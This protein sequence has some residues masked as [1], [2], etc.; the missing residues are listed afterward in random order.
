MDDWSDSSVAGQV[1]ARTLNAI[2][3]APKALV[4]ETLL[5]ILLVRSRAEDFLTSIQIRSL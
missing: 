1:K 5:A 4:G 2:Y 3:T